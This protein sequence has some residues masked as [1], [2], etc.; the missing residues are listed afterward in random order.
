LLSTI[1]QL[2]PERLV[3]PLDA[4]F[5]KITGSIRRAIDPAPLFAPLKALYQKLLDLVALLDMEKILGLILGKT[6]DMPQLLGTRLQGALQERLGSGGAVPLEAPGELFQWGDFLRPFAAIVLQV[7]LKVQTLAESVLGDAL[8]VLQGPLRTLAS[9]AGDVGGLG[10]QLADAIERRMQV[11]DLLAATPAAEDLRLAL[12]DLDAAVASLQGSGEIALQMNGSVA[13]MRLD[14]SATATLNLSGTAAS[15]AERL[16]AAF[17]VA[18]VAVALRTVAERLHQLVPDAL[19]SEAAATTVAERI[20]SLFDVLDFAALADELDAIGARIRA[21]LEGMAKQIF[22]GLI[23]IWNQFYDAILPVTPGGMLQ[24]IQQG[25]Q[26]VRAEFT[27][28]DPAV[29]EQ[30]VREIVDAL[31]DGLEMFSPA[32]LA[33][34]LNGI[35]DSLKAK[36]QQLN[37]A[38]LLGDLTPINN[39]IDQFQQLRPS[40]VLAPL[41]ESTEAVTA[42]LDAILSI[43]FGAEIEAVVA[44]LRGQLEAIVAEVEAEFQALLTFLETQGGGG[45]SVGGTVST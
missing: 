40:I 27:V 12:N 18:D 31:V 17:G 22:A 14:F 2:R 26:R 8:Q 15:H 10:A 16:S 34:Q 43:K 37:P 42:A 20:A 32:A 4:E 38:T 5:K 36:V 21:K 44:K 3:A 25:M 9:I 41:A 6:A 33:G 7:R 24:R 28:L 39:V 45:I 23:G 13:A 29:F 11:L 1:E 35:F 19:L 30:E